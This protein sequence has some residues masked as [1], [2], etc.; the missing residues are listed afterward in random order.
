MNW[1][2]PEVWDKVGVVSLAVLAS[3]TFMVA[4]VR[5]WIVPGRYHREVVADRDREIAELREANDK[6]R[7]ASDKQAET[8]NVLTRALMEKNVTDDTTAKVLI[9]VR[10]ALEEVR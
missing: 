4:L 1:A 10:Q 5:G 8:N 3:V 7:E 6:Q 2:N 9:S